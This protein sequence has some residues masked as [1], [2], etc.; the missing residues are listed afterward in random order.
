MKVP[1]RTPGIMITCTRCDEEKFLSEAE[2]N[3]VAQVYEELPDNWLYDPKFG[4]LCPVCAGLF[5]SYIM[6]FFMLKGICELPAQ[7]Q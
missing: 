1:N 6:D 7:W 3:S 5:R 2:I 4:Y